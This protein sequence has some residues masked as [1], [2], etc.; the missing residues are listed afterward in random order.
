MIDAFLLFLYINH[1]LFKENIL[2]SNSCEEGRF[3]PFAFVCFQ[4][5]LEGFTEIITF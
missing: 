4:V 5:Q 1:F 2:K 3:E